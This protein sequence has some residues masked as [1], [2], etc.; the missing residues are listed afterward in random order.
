M[1]PIIIANPNELPRDR[2]LHALDDVYYPTLEDAARRMKVLT[3][4]VPESCW[5][6]TAGTAIA[7]RKLTTWYFEVMPHA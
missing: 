4:R 5:Q 7:G 6:Y 2:H 3:G 1:T